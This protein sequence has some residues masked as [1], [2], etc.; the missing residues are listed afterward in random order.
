MPERVYPLGTCPNPWRTERISVARR[1]QTPSLPII[2]R[3]AKCGQLHV[4]PGQSVHPMQKFLDDHAGGPLHP[5]VLAEVAAGDRRITIEVSAVCTAADGSTQ[6][7]SSRDGSQRTATK[8][9]LPVP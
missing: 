4:E 1:G 2:V 6:V 8:V 5:V 7:L 3:C 9:W